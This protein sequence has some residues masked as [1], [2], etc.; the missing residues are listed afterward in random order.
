MASILEH[1]VYQIQ[2][3]FV[4]L[5]SSINKTKSTMEKD[6]LHTDPT[7]PPMLEV[8]FFLNNEFF[9]LNSI[10]LLNK[11]HTQDNQ[12]QPEMSQ[13][14]HFL[15]DL[16]CLQRSSSMHRLLKR[17]NNTSSFPSIRGMPLSGKVAFIL[18]QCSSKVF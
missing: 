14:S 9:I 8:H 3:F 16:L 17:R 1:T 11:L 15:R 18:N 12:Q 10:I 2:T 13:L 6:I 5:I 4:L 7:A